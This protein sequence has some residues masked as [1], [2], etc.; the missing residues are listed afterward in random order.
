MQEAEMAMTMWDDGLQEL[1]QVAES[2]NL[3]SRDEKG[4]TGVLTTLA[5]RA[6]EMAY[7]RG[8]QQGLTAAIRILKTGGD[9]EDLR[10]YDLR[11]YKWRN[12]GLRNL[13]HRAEEPPIP[14]TFRQRAWSGTDGC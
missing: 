4:R 12:K 9:L 14:P 5:Q 7:R 13:Y 11:V 10:V 2:R 6:A 1:R 3:Y 8:F